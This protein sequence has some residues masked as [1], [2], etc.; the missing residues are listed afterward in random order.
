MYLH[1][2]ITRK[3][4]LQD[5]F[6]LENTLKKTHLFVK[7]L[8]ALAI[9]GTPNHIFK[10]AFHSITSVWFNMAPPL[11]LLYEKISDLFVFF[12]IRFMVNLR[13]SK[14]VIDFYIHFQ[15]KHV[16]G[17]DSKSHRFFFLL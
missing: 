11:I 8:Y 6:V 3:H 17:Y 4:Y 15:F 10:L 1:Y 16:N 5:T 14:Y 2:V 9:D 7:F 12:L 13:K